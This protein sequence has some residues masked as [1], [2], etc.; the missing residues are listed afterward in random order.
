MINFGNERQARSQILSHAIT[1]YESRHSGKFRDDGEA[2]KAYSLG[3][4]DG[5]MEAIEQMM[6]DLYDEVQLK[7]ARDIRSCLEDERRLLR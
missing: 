6:P 4:L 1:V 2:R 3:F 5:L 7:R